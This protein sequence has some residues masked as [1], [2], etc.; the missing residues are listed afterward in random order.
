MVNKRVA[1]AA[2][3]EVLRSLGLTIGATDDEAERFCIDVI[4]GSGSVK[5]AV[6]ICIW[7]A[8]RLEALP[9]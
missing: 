2:C 9:E 5:N 3:M 7:L 1:W 8:P 4:T 6:D